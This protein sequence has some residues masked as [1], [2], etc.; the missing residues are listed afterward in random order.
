MPPEKLK[1]LR[2][3]RASLLAEA[4]AYITLAD[5]LG[6]DLSD[7]ETKALDAVNAE[8]DTIDAEIEKAEK[9][10]KL[11]SRIAAD[12]E[13]LPRRAAVA[14]EMHDRRQDAPLA[15]FSTPR[16][17]F[18]AVARAE[19]QGRVDERLRPL[20][21]AGGDEQSG[22]SNPHGGFLI[23]TVMRPE[24][25]SI[26]P[27]D[28]PTAARVTEIPME[29]KHIELPYLVDK[30]HSSS[31]VGGQKWMRQAETQAAASSR[32]EYGLLSLVATD[33]TGLTFASDQLLQDSP[34]SIAALIESNYSRGLG[35]TLFE[36]KIRGTGLGEFLG[37]LNAPCTITVAKESGQAAD[38]INGT[39]I[40]KMRQRAWRYGQAVWI[41][42][43]DAMLQI[44]AAHIGLTNDDQ[45]LFKA[46]AGPNGEDLLDGR[47]IFFTEHAST[48][49]DK[50]DLICGV[51]SEY[52]VGTRGAPDMATSMH[53]RFVE[54]EQ[55]FRM[56]V[57]NDGKPWWATALTP[58]NGANT[59]SPFVTLAER[60]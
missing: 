44:M 56:S 3:K 47:P 4:N 35:P 1:A 15:G 41:A 23:P 43:H 34:I 42:N 6:R 32:S 59:L 52:L 22:A 45:Q 14:T 11:R 21:A 38:T 28:D 10:A 5:R 17:F 20:A 31:Y 12:D 25:L 49:G 30:N 18:Q 48:L 54:K 7:D 37:V 24:V 16:E 57:R 19:T 33:L 36:E 8:V 51:W 60:A 13:P 2:E 58:K 29:A 50:G 53:V 55:A 39:N 26:Q 9:M 46:G 27:E 40:R